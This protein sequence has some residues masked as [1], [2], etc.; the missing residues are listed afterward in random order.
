MDIGQWKFRKLGRLGGQPPLDEDH[1]AGVLVRRAA[2]IDPRGWRPA[3]LAYVQAEAQAALLAWLWSLRCPVVNR[4]VPAIWYRPR[5]HL[6]SWQ[7]LLERCGLPVLDTLVT[8]VEEEARRFG[9][10]LAAGGVEGVV[11]G[12]VTSDARYLIAS[13]DD[14]GG[15]AALQ[16]ITPVLL[17]PPHG[18]A[19]LVCVVGERVIWGREPAA[20]R[21]RLETGLRSFAAAADLAFVTVTLAPASSRTCVVAVE[22]NPELEAFCEAAKQEIVEGIVELLTGTSGQTAR[23]MGHGPSRSSL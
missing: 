16:R 19:E 5:A 13:D 12:A 14:W 11:Y 10:R 6:L 17:A 21:A 20:E 2:W 8:N 22:T 7:K 9:R 23:S 18:E 4:C 3:D 15:L 1:I